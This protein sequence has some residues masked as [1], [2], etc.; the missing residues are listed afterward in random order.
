M[1]D[2]IDKVSARQKLAPRREPYWHRISRGNYLGFR[3]MSSTTPGTWVARAR[4]TATG[5]Q[6]YHSLGD[7]SDRPDNERFDSALKAAQAWFTH[8][9]KGGSADALT[10][11]DACDRYVK[12]L[13]ETKCDA[14]ADDAKRRFGQYVLD[15]PTFA[16][17]EVAK[18]TPFH[19]ENWRDK[20]R[21][22]PV[23]Q[24]KR[25]G[26]KS[27]KRKPPT[28]EQLKAA[29]EKP[30]Y[31]R[32]ANTLNRDITPFRAALNLAYED[33]F[34][35]SNFAWKSKLEPAKNV[36]QRRD[37]YLDRDQ[38]REFV[39]AAQADIAMFLRGLCVLPLRPGALAQL[40]VADYN[41]TLKVL[42]IGKDK[43]GKPRHIM[44][45]EETA[46]L[47]AEAAQNKTPAAFLFPRADGK[48]WNKSLWKD[49]VREAVQRAKL[50]AGTL[51]YTV[52]HSVITDL[53]HGGLDLL[54]VAQLA[55]TSVRMI[56]EH[57][58]H[59]RDEVA[60]VALAA[61]AK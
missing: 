47:F 53:V 59:L 51:I 50:P 11:K 23:T 12:H 19:I 35:T 30:K 43:N 54:T 33:G 2:K 20:L 52:R 14:A 17:R 22:R 24:G 26:G 45:P 4:N 6:D 49:P 48:M 32:A 21:L 37:L 61:L 55:G 46:A 31:L 9:G 36:E 15:D 3:K 27:R 10:V 5:K 18:L 38:R 39:A 41:R 56:E 13:R 16:N 42:K 57:Y 34:V 29:A 40:T 25:S 58:G 28:E 1:T 8:L 44:L 7:F 60:Q